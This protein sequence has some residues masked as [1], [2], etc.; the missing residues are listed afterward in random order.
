MYIAEEV[1]RMHNGRVLLVEPNIET[2]PES[3]EEQSLVS[4]EIAF[5]EADIH[6]LLVDHHQLKLQKPSQGVIVDTKGI[7]S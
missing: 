4:T 7:W 1:A 3:L 2:L 5:K 6:L